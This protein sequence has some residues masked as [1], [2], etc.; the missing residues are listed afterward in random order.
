MH[1][2][3]TALAG[4][5]YAAFGLLLAFASCSGPN[6][7][8]AW[9]EWTEEAMGTQFRIKAY[10]EH[11]A[12]VQGVVIGAMVRVQELDAMLSDYQEDSEV[13]QLARAAE[14]A[15]PEDWF[16]LSE[17]LFNILQASRDY[18]E[19][20]DG[21]F[22]PTLGQLTQLWRRTKRQGELPG[23]DRLQSAQ[24]Q[25]GWS[26]IELDERRKRIR[27][28]K[29]GLRL[30]LGGIAKGYALDEALRY[31]RDNGVDSA[32][33]DGGGDIA[34]WA[35]PPD[36]PEGWKIVI[37]G[38]RSDDLLDL[39][40]SY[41]AVATSGDRYQAVEIDGVRYSHVLDPRTGLGVTTPR[42]ASVVAATGMEADAMASALCVLG[43]EGVRKL[44]P[45][46]G[47]TMF[48]TDA[49]Q[50]KRP[51]ILFILADDLG[52]ADLGCQGSE[53]YRTPALDGLAKQGMRF[54]SAYAAAPNCAPTRATLM[55]GTS[56]P[57]HGIY[58]VGTGARGK[59]EDRTVV[60]PKT[61]TQLPTEIVTLAECLQDAGYR[62]GH[63]GKWHLGDY[64]TP[65]GPRAQGFDVNIGGTQVGHPPTFFWPYRKTRMQNNRP[66][67]RSLPG[68]EEGVEGE[69]LTDRLTDEVLAFLQAE[70]ERPW[71]VYL[72]HY[73]VHTPIQAPAEQ[74]AAVE[75]RGLTGK[76]N[77]AT[78]TAMVQSLD[79]SC[80]RILQWLDENGQ[81]DN[82]LVIFTSD[83]G[84]YG[85]YRDAGIDYGDITHN[86]PLKGGKGMLSE[87]GIRVP[88]IV[89][90]P[91]HI[92]AGVEQHT[93]VHTLDYFPTLL[94][95]ASASAPPQDLE[96]RDLAALWN[97][98]SENT[99]GPQASWPE[100]GLYWHMP[101]YLEARRGDWRVRPSGAIR[102]G[103]WKLI[104]SYE[105]GSLQLYNLSTDLGE[106]KN[107]ADSERFK[108]EAL[109]FE[110]AAWRKKHAAAMPK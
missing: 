95:A 57:V 51:N 13:S 63:F 83:N 74:V 101:G 56:I 100:R 16:P 107:L 28:L 32:M 47:L 55:T 90:W 44:G 42:S 85:G 53:S 91:G 41:S 19:A 78:Y 69:Y 64:G 108:A 80:G 7:N 93:P 15:S 96:G 73:T 76:Q 75:K 30:D 36:R 31:M 2:V 4:I 89:R 14:S 62:T 33:I 60:P 66:V 92:E 37:D 72:P 71:F 35:P 94:A 39:Q 25:S 59:A 8:Y 77:N 17:D 67:E 21:A 61:A 82:T 43:D 6:S 27:F 49:P 29:P 105:D 3:P 46:P 81:A 70:D 79:Q 102:M 1:S 12:V 97:T 99:E 24:E 18:V 20:S 87:G 88:M 11:E 23:A 10:H 34:V 48:V 65:T 110:L 5:R 58:T 68:L 98:Q 9:F 106:S 50:P 40:L 38:P 22:D 52:W 26:N 45:R 86:A 103:D 104:E 84:G 109:Q 54:S